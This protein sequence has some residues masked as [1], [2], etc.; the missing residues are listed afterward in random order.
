MPMASTQLRFEAK[1][2]QHFTSKTSRKAVKSWNSIK[3]LWYIFLKI[4][5]GISE[6]TTI[7]TIGWPLTALFR[8]NGRFLWVSAK[9]DVNILFYMFR[10][11]YYYSKTIKKNT[12]NPLLIIFTINCTLVN[13]FFNFTSLHKLYGA[14]LP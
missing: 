5:M 4:L 6:K 14:I 3:T 1:N 13:H 8:W 7:K 2:K 12:V 10:F 11:Y 9:F